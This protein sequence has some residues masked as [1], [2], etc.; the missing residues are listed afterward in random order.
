MVEVLPGKPG[1]KAFPIRN[2]VPKAIQ[3]LS[4]TVLAPFWNRFGT[5]FEPLRDHFGTILTHIRTFS[6]HAGVGGLA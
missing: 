3:T 1:S 6:G 2:L 5:D 4:G